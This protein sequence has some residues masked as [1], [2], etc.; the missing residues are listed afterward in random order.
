[1]K[2]IH[3]LRKPCSEANV[4]ANVLR[5]GTG[6]IN[7][8]GCRIG[9]Q[10]E[11]DL[12][13]TTKKNQHIDFDTGPRKGVVYGDFSQEHRKNYNG[14]AGRW[15]ANLILQHLDGCVRDGVVEEHV[16]INR[17]N[18]GMKPFGEGAGHQYTSTTSTTSTTLWRCQSG[19]PISALDESVGVQ[20]SHG[21]VAPSVSSKSRGIVNFGPGSH[22]SGVNTPMKKG[23][24]VSRFFKQIK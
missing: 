15:P 13:E 1:M 9:F 7:I 12:S 16:T 4:A 3:V 18:D 23:G 24:F 2:V 17:F 21:D 8:D 19:C 22:R 20:Q 6:A 14:S 10:S 11:A 5:H